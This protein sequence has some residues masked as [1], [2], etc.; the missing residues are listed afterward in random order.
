MNCPSDLSIGRVERDIPHQLALPPVAVVEKLFLVVEQFLARLAR[1]FEIWALDDRIHRARLLAKSAVDAFHHVDVIARRAARAVVAAGTCFD[2][3]RLCRTDGLAE[4][5]GDAALFPI[6]VAPQRVLAAK[7]R[8]DRV[9]LE[10]IVDRR[11]CREKI[12]HGEAD[13]R[14]EL[15]EEQGTRRSRQSHVRFSCGTQFSM[16]RSELPNRCSP[17]RNPRTGSATSPCSRMRFMRTAGSLPC[18]PVTFLRSWRRR[19]S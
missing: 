11:L 12:P 18:V 4:L 19:M 1:E 15:G 2:S 5:A 6:G 16:S 13:R 9:L 14:N 10:R 8:R 7:P 3:D 17:N